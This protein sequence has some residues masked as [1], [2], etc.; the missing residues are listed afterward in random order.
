MVYGHQKVVVYE[1]HPRVCHKLCAKNLEN[2]TED[3]GMLRDDQ[4]LTMEVEDAC[5]R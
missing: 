2:G 4:L 5:N 3:E 1:G